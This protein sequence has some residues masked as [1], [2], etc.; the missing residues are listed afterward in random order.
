[1]VTLDNVNSCSW[2][3]NT[4]ITAG[5]LTL[6]ANQVT[7]ADGVGVDVGDRILC[8]CDEGGGWEALWEMRVYDAQ[9]ASA[10]DGT[11][12]FELANDLRLLDESDDFFIYKTNK[13]H[14]GGW[15]G[16]DIIRDVCRRYGVRIGGLYRG[17]KRIT[18]PQTSRMHGRMTHGTK[19]R[20]S[21]LDVIRNVVVQERRLD[22]RRLVVRYDRGRL[23]VI[24]LTR[25]PT[26]MKIGPTLN[27]M[28][29]EAQL[30]PE[31]A[32]SV[33]L[34]G[35][36][37]AP[38]DN[39]GG[40][41]P[42]DQSPVKKPWVELTSPQSVRRYG[43]VHKVLY[44]PDAR[45][46]TE[47][48]NEAKRFLAQV[49]KPLRTATLTHQVLPR[50]KRGDAVT[51]QVGP[52]D[53]RHRIVWVGDV[54]HELDAAGQYQT[55]LTLIWNNPFV[56]RRNLIYWKLK[57]T[58]QEAIGNRLT[59]NP[60]YYIRGDNKSDQAGAGTSSGQNFDDSLANDWLKG[61]LTGPR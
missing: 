47:L 54:Q 30:R 50:V 27:E 41:L 12:E 19:V 22:G 35:L 46:R 1:V 60:A 39:N 16:H 26:L 49:G 15:Y 38:G 42:F 40:P 24:P 20:M 48:A 3:D 36:K 17:R 8:A 52:S 10:A 28:Q 7:H 43:F 58:K 53:V 11:W 56:P 2:S 61:S 9:E 18:I 23:F 55:T 31:F 44:S 13:A 32:S 5:T 57:G 25:N 6:T 37:T 33:M 59:R 34:W 45:N 21:P 51:L 4:A 14:P 29:M